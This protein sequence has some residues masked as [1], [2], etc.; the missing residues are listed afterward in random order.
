[1]VSSATRLN[2]RMIQ[3]TSYA[4]KRRCHPNKDGNAVSIGYTLIQLGKPVT[5]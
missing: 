3:P 1:M 2:F 5:E 4:K